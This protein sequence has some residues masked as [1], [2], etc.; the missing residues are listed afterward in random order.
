MNTLNIV[1]IT[2]GI[3]ILYSNFLCKKETFAMSPST[4]TQLRANSTSNENLNHQFV[5]KDCGSTDIVVNY[6]RRRNYG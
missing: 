4:L 2:I 5:C 3:Y 6:N 1:L